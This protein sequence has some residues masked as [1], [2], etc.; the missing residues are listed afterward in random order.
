M[1]VESLTDWLVRNDLDLSREVSGVEC[2]SCS[3]SGEQECD[4]GHYHDCEECDG[5]GTKEGHSDP[6]MIEQL[7]QFD[8]ITDLCLLAD[9]CYEFKTQWWPEFGKLGANIAVFADIKTRM[10]DFERF[11][12]SRPFKCR[13]NNT[14][15]LHA[16][17]EEGA[18]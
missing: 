9:W 7:Y 12:T 15:D 1:K 16:P 5:S 17:I 11:Y 14:Q 2:G 18:Q 6:V 8:V 13:T 4:M 3:G 10:L